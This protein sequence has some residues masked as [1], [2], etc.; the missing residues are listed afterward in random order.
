M[1]EKKIIQQGLCV[2]ASEVA[3]LQ[4]NPAQKDKEGVVVV[5]AYTAIY[6]KSG[7]VIKY[8]CGGGIFSKIVAEV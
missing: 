5:G 6:L 1:G 2:V 7:A 4:H 3:A 8:T